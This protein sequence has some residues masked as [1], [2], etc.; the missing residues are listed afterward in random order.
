LKVRSQFRYS[1]GARRSIPVFSKSRR[2]AL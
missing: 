2:R 1:K